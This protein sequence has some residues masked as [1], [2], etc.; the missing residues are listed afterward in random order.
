MCVVVG[1]L[2]LTYFTHGLSVPAATLGQVSHSDVLPVRLQPRPTFKD[3]DVCP[4]MVEVPPGEFMMGSPE[5]EVGRDG[6][7]GPQRRV[8]LME[9]VALGKFEIT[10]DQFAAFI[11]ETGLE[12]SDLCRVYSLN[13]RPSEWPL[14]KGSFLEPGFR[15]TGRHP[16]VCVSWHDAKAYTAWL[17][18]KTGRPY[19]LPTEAEWEYVARAGMTGPYGFGDD[20]ARLCEFARFAD[21]DSSFPW[22]SGCHSAMFEPG[23]LSVGALAPNPWGLFDMHGNAWEWTE[24]CWTS[25]ARLLPSDGSAYGRSED[26]AARTVRGGGWAAEIRKV[27]SAQRMRQPADARYYHIGFRV[28]LPLAPP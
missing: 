11:A 19:R 27:R 12:T 22:R 2:Y 25:D 26:C 6:V 18:R 17:N 8:V 13:A 21:G 9:G 1:I 3:C 16:A 20:A 15:V 4:E 10:I 7:E 24:D 23:A 28:A 14:V 5:G